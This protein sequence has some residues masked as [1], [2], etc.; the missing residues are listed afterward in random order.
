MK[1]SHGGVALV[2]V[3]ALTAVAVMPAGARS[4]SRTCRALA[5]QRGYK[6]FDHDRDA[7][8]FGRRDRR[9]IRGCIRAGRKA[10]LLR[11]LCC[12]TKF[13]LGGRFVA[14]SYRGTAIGDETSKVGAI[15]L[16][17]GRA[18][19]YPKLDSSAEGGGREIETGSLVSRF[20]VTPTGTLVWV[21]ALDSAQ[22]VYE[23]RVADREE[24]IVDAGVIDPKSV[25]LAA[26]GNSVSYTK[27][28][29]P[30]AARLTA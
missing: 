7:I 1:L 25:K 24:R 20:F 28:G 19:A 16:R 10:F 21:L 2:L 30:E 11:S 8:V 13:E 3:G 27:D 15:D 26:G 29:A 12:G 5:E 18:V 17:G 6:V 4:K 22:G 23:I 9:V 14:Y